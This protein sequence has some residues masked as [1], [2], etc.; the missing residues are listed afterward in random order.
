MKKIVIK[1]KSLY[2]DFC[3]YEIEGILEKFPEIIKY[4]IHRKFNI[5]E[6]FLDSHEKNLIKNIEAA[7]NKEGLEVLQVIGG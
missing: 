1:F 6:V 2:C 3:T 7:F 4:K 5:L